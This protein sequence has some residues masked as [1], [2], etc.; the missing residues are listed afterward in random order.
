MI[1]ESRREPGA[2]A[3]ASAGPGKPLGLA[4]LVGMAVSG[5]I[6]MPLNTTMLALAL[7]RVMAELDIQ[8]SAAGWLMTAYLI[9]GAASLAIAGRLGD[10]YGQQRVFNLGLLSFAAASMV[11]ALAPNFA[12]LLVGRVL[13]GATGSAIVPNGFALVRY[14]AAPRQRGRAFGFVT[15]SNATAATVAPALGGFIV[16]AFNWQAI[17]LLNLAFVAVSLVLGTFAAG[18]LA[19][20]RDAGTRLDNLGST[21]LAAFSISLALAISIRGGG[22]IP[23]GLQPWL[24]A[25]AVLSFLLF[26]VQEHHARV[27]LVRL[28]LLRIRNF[29]AATLC[30]S[31]LNLTMYGFYL[32]IPLILQDI[33]GYSPTGAGVMMLLFTGAMALAAPFGGSLSDRVGRRLIPILGLST[34]A[35]SGLFFLGIEAGASPPYVL[36]C[37][38]GIGAGSGMTFPVLQTASLE[39]APP[40]HTGVASGVYFTARYLG[41]SIGTSIIS[42]TTHGVAPGALLP[43]YRLALVYLIIFA[44]VAVLLAAALQPRFDASAWR[45]ARRR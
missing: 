38:L 33:L 30:S 36:A 22:R 15:C 5:T 11:C 14:G 3:G 41:G 32:L 6:L 29:L 20:P 8:V 1:D 44:A 7:P 23:A 28:S 21:L 10:M 45:L 27:P 43:A 17:F 12:I 40:E 9:T 42:G 13:Q 2:A 34:L 37:F 16:E 31:F 4:L 35:V 18:R 26:L 25:I 39:A 19:T 24:I